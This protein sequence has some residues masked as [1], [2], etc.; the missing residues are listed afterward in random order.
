MFNHSTTMYDGLAEQHHPIV[1]TILK[2]VSLEK[3]FLLGTTV[4]IGIQKPCL[5]AS[6]QLVGM[7][8][9]TIYWYSYQKPT[10]T[11]M[12]KFRIK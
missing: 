10:K 5:I 11:S 8:L 4:S 12:L 2:A 6:Q 1:E 9:I 3:I 7:Y